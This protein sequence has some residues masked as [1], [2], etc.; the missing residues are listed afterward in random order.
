VERRL[1]RPAA[2]QE[3][4]AGPRGRLAQ[5]LALLGLAAC[6][7]AFL[8]EAWPLSPHLDDAYIS[9]RYARNL[10]EG[11]GLVYNPGEYVE[12]FTN[13]LW[14]LL[15]AAG[16][17]LGLEA[18]AVAHGLGLASGV[19]LLVATFGYAR[20]GLAKERAWLASLAPALLLCS[21]AFPRWSTSGMETPLF[22]AAILAALWAQAAGRMGWATASICVATLTRPDGAVLAAVVFAFLLPRLRGEGPR[23]L[24]GPAVWLGLLALL[25]VLRLAYYGSAVPNTFYAKV[26]GVPLLLGTQY[27]AAFLT[28]GAGFLL[29][30]AAAAALREPALRPGA[31]FAAVFSAYVVAVGGDVFAHGRF[32]L[33][34]LAVLAVLAVRGTLRL[35]QQRLGLGLA[36][37][38]CLAL[39]AWVQ[40]YG[41]APSIEGLRE[42]KR[43]A[44]VQAAR[45]L[46]RAF[47]RGGR[48][49]TAVIQRRGQPVRLVAV[50]GIGAFGYYSR[51]PIVDL[52][53]L[54]DVAIARGPS[55]SPGGGY[56]VP[57]HVR[58]NADYILA[59]EP[60]YI[61]MPKKGAPALLNAHLDL[62]AH[63]DFE[64]FYAWDA[65]LKGYRRRASVDR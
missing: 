34:V 1:S 42:S 62:W 36:A 47:E 30:P 46:D 48:R 61:L 19:A 32:L 12:G 25:S 33:P 24:L 65:E 23:V 16:L 20:T 60:D 56:P 41:G 13:L 17:A 28:D 52:L 10:V 54:V 4:R 22:A 8:S 26:P 40:V 5:G 35:N 39:A 18:K 50:T 11:A 57:G 63:P 2:E 29:L 3:D 21:I 27:L 15:V 14:T 31:L 55:A 51:L 44:A 6:I 9:Y 43:A 53:G 49:K 37:T 45:R 59:R 58:S 64:R 7:G 38:A